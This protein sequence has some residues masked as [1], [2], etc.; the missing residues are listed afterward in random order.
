MTVRLRATGRE[1]K[2]VGLG[3]RRGQGVVEK[4]LGTG[5]PTGGMGGGLLW[6][7]P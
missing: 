6:E 2:A 5:L 3:R 4:G 1:L 7:W